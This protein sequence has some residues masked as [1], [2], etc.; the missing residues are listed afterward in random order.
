MF[1][2]GWFVFVVVFNKLHRKEFLEEL[3]RI[4]VPHS[5]LLGAYI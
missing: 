2:F 3:L 1:L 5:L 4:T